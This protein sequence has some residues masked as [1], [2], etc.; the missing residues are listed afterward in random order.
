MLLL[1]VLLF[2]G[3][4]IGITINMISTIFPF[5]HQMN[6]IE[7]YYTSYYGAVSAIEQWLLVSKYK[8][9]W[10]IWSWLNK[11]FWISRNMEWKV[12]SRTDNIADGS[13]NYLY[14]T[15]KNKEKSN[16]NYNKV[17]TIFFNI[18]QSSGF[19][20]SSLREVNP[21]EITPYYW[22]P[23]TKKTLSQ[24]LEKQ[25]KQ[26]MKNILTNVSVASLSWLNIAKQD[27][28]LYI[29]IDNNFRFSDWSKVPLLEYSLLF[30]W[31]KVGD[32]KFD[33]SG[34]AQAKDYTTE[35]N[36]KRPTKDIINPDFKKSL[37]PT[38]PTP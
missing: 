17:A 2:M 35:I 9:S 30:N 32:E 11:S 36:I 4:I 38:K 12:V 26:E 33:I 22:V 18:D 1:A 34:K 28:V 24:E 15:G 20:N 27:N 19:S 10:F 5:M 23:N 21:L 14:W 13:I 29:W 6:N 37:F 25:L 3:I 8:K 31:D 16:L 7:N